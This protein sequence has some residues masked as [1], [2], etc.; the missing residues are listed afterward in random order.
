MESLAHNTKHRGIFWLGIFM[1]F[2]TLT[3]GNPTYAG[4]W[5]LASYYAY[6]GKITKVKSLMK[7]LIILNLVALA[8]VWLFF[9]A[10]MID[11]MGY[12]H[13]IDLTIDVFLALIPKVGLYFYCEKLLNPE[14]NTHK[15]N[16]AKA[17]GTG[18]KQIYQ[19]ND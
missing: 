5:F 11:W 4:F 19:K 17:E 13:K 9:D 6:K 10:D 8:L 2:F 18:V 12:T 1:S 14:K 15:S 7:W 3:V 16:V